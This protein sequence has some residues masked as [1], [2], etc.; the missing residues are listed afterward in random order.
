MEINLGNGSDDDKLDPNIIKGNFFKKAL[1]KTKSK[2]FSKIFSLGSWCSVNKEEQQFADDN[3]FVFMIPTTA[4]DSYYSLEYIIS[5]LAKA[6][7]RNTKLIIIFGLNLENSYSNRQQI[8]ETTNKFKS[9][10]AIRQQNL[11]NALPNA[12]ILIET[13]TW[14]TFLA[15]D[16][17]IIVPY[18]RIRNQ[19]FYTTAHYLEKLLNLDKVILFMLDSDLIINFE[20]LEYSKAA[21]CLA[22]SLGYYYSKNINFDNQ[23]I[24]DLVLAGN[25]INMLIKQNPKLC[26]YVYLSEPCYFI[27]GDALKLIMREVLV[28]K[29][30]TEFPCDLG[31]AEVRGINRF[32]RSHN[33]IPKFLNPGD[34]NVPITNKMP[35]NANKMTK[36]NGSI[37]FALIKNLLFGDQYSSAQVIT[38]VRELCTKLHI[39]ELEPILMFLANCIFLPSLWFNGIVTIDKDTSAAF[40][41][42]FI[43]DNSQNLVEELKKLSK[44][45]NYERAESLIDT[46]KTWGLAVN[47]AFYKS[48]ADFRPELATK[49][50]SE[51]EKVAAEKPHNLD[52]YLNKQ[53]QILLHEKRLVTPSYSQE[54]EDTSFEKESQKP[55]KK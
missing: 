35:H 45:L 41:N 28:K 27:K 13:F 36:Y 39:K 25:K 18:G 48:Y 21:K 17:E 14:K 19:L 5:M 49:I 40:I 33:I 1:D 53:F 8:E 4:E 55:A 47:Y 20:L 30:H 52:T 6:V 9:R 16:K 11:Q 23:D 2:S 54:R 10:W 43:N 12:T 15:E 51:I 37:D 34:E 3:I 29:E 24:K 42:K 31:A 32:L 7:L 44:H 50:K 38:F 46:I 26:D 22:G